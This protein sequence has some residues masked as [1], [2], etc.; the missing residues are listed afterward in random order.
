MKFSS[1]TIFV[2]YQITNFKHEIQYTQV[3]ITRATSKL[4]VL[5]KNHIDSVL[6]IH[7]QLKFRYLTV[8]L[9]ICLLTIEP[10]ECW[11]RRRFRR[12]TRRVGRAIRRVGR[13]VR[14]VNTVVGVIR[15]VGGI[16]GA[17]KRSAD[18]V[19]QLWESLLILNKEKYVFDG[20]F[21][22]TNSNLTVSV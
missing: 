19:S 20:F 16:A 12:F 8:L 3:I 6:L 15:A 5:Y 11:R 10:S 21:F 4:P 18:N 2:I 1:L 7:I 9:L 17:G 22:F 13:T 14:T